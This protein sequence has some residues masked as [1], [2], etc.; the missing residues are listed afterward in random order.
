MNLVKHYIK[1]VVSE[2]P[3]EYKKTKELNEDFVKVTVIVDCYGS[4]GEHTVIHHKE[5]W[6]K[7]Q[8]LGYYWG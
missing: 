6:E 8:K 2:E 4:A 5:D 7:I 1:E 3:Y